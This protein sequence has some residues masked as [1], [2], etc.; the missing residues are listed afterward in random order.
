ME[1]HV[2]PKSRL[3][4]KG[5]CGAIIPY[6]RN[7]QCSRLL[8][9]STLLYRDLRLYEKREHES[10]GGGSKTVNELVTG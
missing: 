7:L 5:L 2:A 9:L 3:T 6:D 1:K 4:F 8:L 10:S